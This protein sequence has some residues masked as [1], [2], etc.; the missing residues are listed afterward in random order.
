MILIDLMSLQVKTAIKPIISISKII[1]VIV[2][3]TNT[4]NNNTVSIITNLSNSMLSTHNIKITISIHQTANTKL[5]NLTT[6][7]NNM[8]NTIILMTTQTIKTL[9]AMITINSIISISKIT[10]QFKTNNTIKQT[11]ITTIAKARIVMK[12]NNIHLVNMS[13]NPLFQQYK[14]IYRFHQI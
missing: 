10:E 1:T 6:N 14:L 4:I 3:E 12:A 13:F 5:N 7:I 2:I 11:N 8:H 9:D